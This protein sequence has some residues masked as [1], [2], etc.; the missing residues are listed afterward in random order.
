LQLGAEI[1][2]LMREPSI[3]DTQLSSRGEGSQAKCDDSGCRIADAA[4]K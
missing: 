1:M 4:L 2:A 3:G